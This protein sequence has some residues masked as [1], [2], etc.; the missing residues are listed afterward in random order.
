MDAVC[1]MFIPSA[2]GISDSMYIWTCPWTCIL[3]TCKLGH[4]F[5]GD[6]V[7]ATATGRC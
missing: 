7:G 5:K 6:G 4:R 3:C 2:T 1:M